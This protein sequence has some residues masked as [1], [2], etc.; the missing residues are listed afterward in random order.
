MNGRNSTWQLQEAKNKLSEVIRRAREEGPQI[1]T[2]R[3]EPAA[4]VTAPDPGPRQ[5]ESHGE[6]FL[7]LAERMAASNNEPDADFSRTRDERQRPG[8]EF[9]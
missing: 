1:I 6:F 7:R 5:L 2:V 8:V 9:D 3:G 4:V